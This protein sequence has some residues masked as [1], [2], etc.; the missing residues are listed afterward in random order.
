MSDLKDIN[1]E[2]AAE[3][4]KTMQATMGWQ[5]LVRY[6]AEEREAI[7]TEGKKARREEKTIKTWAI[8][9]GYDK[10]IGL[11]DRIVQAGKKYQQVSVDED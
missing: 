11:A 9:E 1:P 6:M 5:I 2:S 4:I 3:H 10:F 7:L 8:L